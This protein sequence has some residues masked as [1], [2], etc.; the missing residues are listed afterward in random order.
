MSLFPEQIL[1]HTFHDQSLLRQALTHPSYLN[2]VRDTGFTDY[3]RLEFLGDAVLGLLLADFLYTRYPQLPEGDLS[4]LRSTLVDQ[5]RLAE[6]AASVNISALILLGRGEEQDG[7]R[8]KPSILADVL[9]AVIG[10]IYC[11]AGFGVVRPIVAELYASLLVNTD[12]T[13]SFNDAKS[14]LQELLVARKQPVPVYTLISEEGPA[15]DRQFKVAA[16]V[17]DSCIGTGTGRSKKTAQQAA[18]QAAL[19]H[20]KGEE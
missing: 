19:A 4:R 3:Q 9:E 20:L 11:D 10:A 2:E 8:L 16:M 7:G 12:L 14:E 13:A 15:H 18:A 6:L 1:G 5:S 17:A